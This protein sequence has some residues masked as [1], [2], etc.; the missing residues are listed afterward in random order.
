[1]ITV[2]SSSYLFFHLTAERW[3]EVA[4]RF[5]FVFPEVTPV[6][7]QCLTAAF[8]KKLALVK[9]Q[10][11]IDSIANLSSLPEK[12]NETCKTCLDI[13][14]ELQDLDD[15][16]ENKKRIQGQNEKNML[17]H[18]NPVRSM[19]LELTVLLFHHFFRVNR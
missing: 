9:T 18:E 14:E 2:L 7:T 16:L 17:T 4:R 11:G 15:L 3:A 13:A 8:Q 19:H 6:T 5:Y 12:E 1:M 10:Y